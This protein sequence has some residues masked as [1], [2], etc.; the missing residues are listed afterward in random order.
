MLLNISSLK[1]GLPPDVTNLSCIKFTILLNMNIIS[2][3][4]LFRCSTADNDVPLT[5]YHRLNKIAPPS[6]RVMMAY[7]NSRYQSILSKDY[8]TTSIP[9]YTPFDS[10]RSLLNFRPFSYNS[11]L[12]KRHDVSCPRGLNS[13]LSVPRVL[14]HWILPHS[15]WDLSNTAQLIRPKLWI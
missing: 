12:Y 5:I 3:F 11:L 14:K 2:T 9:P 15:V 7:S 6:S 4:T 13:T 1:I 8:G 10:P